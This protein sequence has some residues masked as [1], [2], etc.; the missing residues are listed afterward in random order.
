MQGPRVQSSSG[1]PSTAH[2]QGHRGGVDD[3][4]AFYSRL[5]GRPGSVL[6]STSS[7]RRPGS[8][9]LLPTEAMEPPLY[10]G[11]DGLASRQGVGRLQ[12]DD[13]DSEELEEYLSLR[14]QIESSFGTTDAFTTTLRKGPRI[15]PSGAGAAALSRT[16]RSAVRVPQLHL[17]ELG[18][19]QDDNDDSD[20]LDQDL[21]SVVRELESA[22]LSARRAAATEEQGTALSML[23]RAP[24]P[25]RG[26][27]RPKRG[28]KGAS[29][30]C[31]P[32]VDTSR[33]RAS[34]DC[35]AP[36]G[37]ARAIVK[38]GQRIRVT[39]PSASSLRKSHK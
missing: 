25:I 36:L 24:S 4:M 26:A 15:V 33:S 20:E 1:R 16:A 17:D 31:R 8:V 12:E 37:T 32:P 3:E 2:A 6:H 22:R 28:P 19:A 30:T 29:E 10:G 7:A 38:P 11:V 23:A 14:G 39:V 9:K 21:V 34:R 27:L 5:V 35:D 13:A 18:L